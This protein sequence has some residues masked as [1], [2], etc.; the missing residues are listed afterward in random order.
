MLEPLG[1]VNK[2]A[3]PSGG[4]PTGWAIS[5]KLRL[6]AAQARVLR[7]YTCRFPLCGGH[8]VTKAS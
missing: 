4:S 1:F 6:R 7:D 5:R 2:K 3:C 8:F